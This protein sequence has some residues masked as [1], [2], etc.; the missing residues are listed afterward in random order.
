GDDED[1]NGDDENGDD[2]N[3]DDEKGDNGGEEPVD[4]LEITIAADSDTITIGED[5][6]LTADVQ[7]ADDVTIAWTSSL[8]GSFEPQGGPAV[9]WTP[10][11]MGQVIITA[12]ATA[13]GHDQPVVDTIEITVL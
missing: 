7:G 13:P 8:D 5:V 4:P 3:G 2:E 11:A 9:T 6:N 1:E 10:D 12:T